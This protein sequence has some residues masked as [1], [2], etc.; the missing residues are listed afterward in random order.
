M[1]NVAKNFFYQSIFQVAK[2]IIPIVTI[3]IVSNALGPKGIGIYNYTFSIAQYFVLFAGLGVTIYGNREIALAWNKG[4]MGLSKTFWEIFTF[5]AIITLGV[6]LLYII[7][8]FFL[9]EKIFLYVQALTIL[10][11]F[12]DISWF[13]MGIEDF[14]KTSMSNLGVQI[15]TFILIILFIKDESDAIKYTL[16]QGLGLLLSQ[17]IVWMFIPKYIQLFKVSIKSS[18]KHLKGSF[19]FFIPQ[20]AIILYTNLN[21]TILGAV[22]GSAAVGY[23][24]NSLQINTVFISVITTLDLVLLP[25]MTGLFAKKDTDR[26][27][28]TMEKTVHLQ[29]FFSIPIMFG[30]LTVYDKL[31]PWFF[32]SK[33]I[34]IN[35]VIPYFTILVVIIPL[36]LSVSRQYLMPVGHIKEYNKSVIIGAIINIVSNLILL[37]TVGFFGVVIS[38]ILAEFFVT[39]VRTSSFLRETQ[40]RFDTRKIIVFVLSSMIMCVSTRYLTRNLPPSLITNILQVCIALPM[41]F[42]LTVIG[43]ENLIIDF[44]KPRWRK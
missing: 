6:L 10:A 40:F 27:V 16:I 22:L 24:T 43:K 35:N 7:L 44:I 29:L 15:L 33:F 42:I 34:Y 26:I 8:S 39:F 11:V 1:K 20:V 13:F 37:P 28:Q 30:M 3:P 21:K 12:F 9:K 17:V 5:K 25:Y 31:I 23:F 32:G 36:G 41:Y 38:N 14:K 19:E 18:L 4:K 2:I